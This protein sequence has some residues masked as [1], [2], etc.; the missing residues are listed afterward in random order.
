MAAV[1]HFWH[2]S[3]EDFWDLTVEEYEALRRYQDRYHEEAQKQQARM[4]RR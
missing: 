3:P 4:R 2:L 1:C